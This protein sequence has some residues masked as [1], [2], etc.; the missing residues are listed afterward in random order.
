MKRA[1]KAYPEEHAMGRALERLA[2]ASALRA[3]VRM[4][5]QISKFFEGVLK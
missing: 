2:T 5:I 4:C 3:V 1:G